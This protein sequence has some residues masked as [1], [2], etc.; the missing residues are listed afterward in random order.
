MMAKQSLLKLDNG[1]MEFII[2]FAPFLFVWKLYNKKSI[3]MLKMNN[4]DIII[5]NSKN[6]SRAYT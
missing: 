1:Y 6:F 3:K 4:L 2:L 5:Q